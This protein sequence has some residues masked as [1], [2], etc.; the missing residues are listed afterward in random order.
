MRNSSFVKVLFRSFAR[1]AS[2]T[3][4]T[5]SR[6][7]HR[8]RAAFTTPLLGALA[9]VAVVLASLTGLSPVAR[10]AEL[11]NAITDITLQGSSEVNVGSVVNF[12][13]KWVVPDGSA[14]GDTFTLQLPAELKWRGATSFDIT[15]CEAGGGEC[16]SIV[17]ATAVVD[18]NGLVTFTLSDYVDGRVD[19][20]GSFFFT[21]EFVGENSDGQDQTVTFSGSLPT[22]IDV[23]LPIADPVSKLSITKTASPTAFPA[24]AAS[25]GK[26]I[27]YKM[28]V[29]NTGQQAL[30]GVAVSDPGPKRDGVAADG[31]VSPPLCA[32][33]PGTSDKA[34]NPD[35][36]SVDLLPGESTTFT[37]SYTL[38]QADID[39]SALMKNTAT[40]VGTDQNDQQVS[41]TDQASVKVGNVAWGRPLSGEVVGTTTPEKLMWWL[42]NPVDRDASAQVGAIVRSGYIPRNSTDTA[43]TLTFTEHPSPGL[44]ID[45]SAVPYALVFPVT[46]SGDAVPID[47]AEFAERTGMV[48]QTVESCSPQELVF[49]VKW[50]SAKSAAP[51]DPG[52]V[53]VSLYLSLRVTDWSL[54]AVVDG[55]N[56]QGYFN[57]AVLNLDGESKEVTAAL[58]AATSS[59]SQPTNDTTNAKKK[60]EWVASS[61]ESQIRVWLNSPVTSAASSTVVLTE[62]LTTPGQRIDCQL[63]G[64]MNPETYF[65]VWEPGAKF[66][67]QQAT[68]TTGEPV[69]GTVIACSDTSIT[70]Q[71]DD[72]PPLVNVGIYL[73]VDIDPSAGRYP[74]YGDEA[75]IVITGQAPWS[76]SQSLTRTEAG[77]TGSGLMPGAIV[78]SEAS[79]GNVADE[80]FMPYTGNDSVLRDSV[81]VTDSFSGLKANTAHTIRGVLFDETTG[82]LV[83]DRDGVVVVGTANADGTGGLPGFTSTNIGETP[84]GGL[85]VYFRVPVEVAGHTLVAYQYVYNDEDQLAAFADDS[86]SFG[87]PDDA[88][89]A[90]K[91]RA[92]ETVQVEVAPGVVAWSKTDVSSGSPIGGATFMLLGPLGYAEQVVDNTG[93]AGYS[94]L[95]TD[96][97]AGWFAVTGLIPETNVSEPQYTITEVTA[98]NGY[99]LDTHNE[100][101]MAHDPATGPAP[102]WP[103]F[104]N[105]RKVGQVSW[106]K[107]R[108]GD[109]STRLPGS[110][111]LLTG[112]DGYCETIT[113][114]GSKL[115]S[116][117]LSALGTCSS[118]MTLSDLAPGEFEMHDL[119]W[120]SYQLSEIA[121]PSGYQL[122][123]TSHEF[124][125]GPSSLSISLGA[126]ENAP[127]LG[128]VTWEKTDD[129]SGALLPGSRWL[130][131]GPDGYS[132]ELADNDPSDTN[133]ADGKLSVE[134]LPWGNYTL[135]ETTPPE[136]YILD[137]TP[138]ELVVNAESDAVGDFGVIA[139][140]MI[141]LKK[142]PKTLVPTLL[143]PPPV[144]PV[145]SPSAQSPKLDALS[146]TGAD[147]LTP[148][149]LGV[150][151]SLLLL[152]GGVV[153]LR[154]AGH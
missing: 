60:V 4:G 82:Q 77:G 5:S 99:I 50:I 1:V 108:E 145:Q 90:A 66:T 10:A 129:T 86:N 122:D 16:A 32:A 85:N 113:D 47:D 11:L 73:Y 65:G 114:T 92:A 144:V 102:D 136:G 34:C 146:N 80:K 3:R 151:G 106:A 23:T 68:R 107:S 131:T 57:T 40:A 29:K 141:P 125:V 121:A 133:S 97:R 118:S 43:H 15:L 58:T 138:H 64:N 9:V 31:I 93:E 140:A 103:E 18:E 104:E 38:T 111:W 75:S 115:S 26:V 17:V 2:G 37:A 119:A 14:A 63:P 76:Q 143:A 128:K 8:H 44:A 110:V 24:T 59:S 56:G 154:R 135:S 153:I 130:L 52:G 98:P 101:L 35:G 74:S 132:R 49:T 13:G 148:L 88:E 120:G 87:F 22:D 139:D 117:V 79:T 112:P 100:T 152:L 84:P 46:T 91:A 48:E 116:L 53:S 51:N 20:S 126:L 12:K 21:T 25:I 127:K 62:K 105:E 54:A 147:A 81:S 7:R 41:A 27:T 134:G 36:V 55:G 30:T 83:T 39:A 123:H 61:N 96:P 142:K 94:G 150:G 95:D 42:G 89:A 67:Y 33:R 71:F 45:C 78:R 6:R 19:V 137:A 149:W 109:A 28:V 70:V 69:T 72:V 124:E